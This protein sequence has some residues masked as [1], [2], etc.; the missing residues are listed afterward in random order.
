MTCK[1]PKHLG[2][3]PETYLGDTASGQRSIQTWSRFILATLCPALVLPITSCTAACLTL[4]PSSTRFSIC[5]SPSPPLLLSLPLCLPLP[6]SQSLCRSLFLLLSLSLLSLRVSL[7]LSLWG[8][9]SVATSL[10][11]SLAHTHSLLRAVAPLRSCSLARFLSFSSFP[12][13]PPSWRA[14]SRWSGSR[15]VGRCVSALHTLA[16]S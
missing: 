12:S 7:L 15:I 13:S 1:P 5:L 3:T 10:A 8:A 9:V 11:F 2:G 16:A 4:P 14:L 6:L